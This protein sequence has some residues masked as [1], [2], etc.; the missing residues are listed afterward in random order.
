MRIQ[1]T[2]PGSLPTGLV[3]YDAGLA[4]TIVMTLVIYFASLAGLSSFDLGA[5][6][7]SMIEGRP[8][9]SGSG[10][11]WLAMLVHLLMG[12]YAIPTLYALTFYQFVPR[13]DW[14]LGA[15]YG[16]CLWVM[17][18]AVLVGASSAGSLFTALLGFLSYGII[19]GVVSAPHSSLNHQLRS[20]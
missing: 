9:P 16:F 15:L 20:P 10:G 2:I 7:A 18:A 14:K 1:K 17:T 6:L 8:V 11:W 19:F 3:I 4:G 5:I 13:F 12:T